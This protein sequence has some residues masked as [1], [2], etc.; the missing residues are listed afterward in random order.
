MAMLTGDLP[1]ITIDNLIGFKQLVLEFKCDALLRKF[2]VF[3]GDDHV[4]AQR[5]DIS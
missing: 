1:Y 5:E 2:T 4:L 3:A